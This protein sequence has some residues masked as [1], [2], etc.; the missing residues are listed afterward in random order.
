MLRCQELLCDCSLAL[1]EMRGLCSSIVYHVFMSGVYQGASWCVELRND[2]RITVSFGLYR[3]EYLRGMR[4]PGL[5][6]R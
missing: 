3:A 1:L 2:V 5:S 4:R 6:R